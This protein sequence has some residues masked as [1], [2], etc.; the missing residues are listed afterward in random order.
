MDALSGERGGLVFVARTLPTRWRGASV[1][2][3]ADVRL[4]NRYGMEEPMEAGSGTG[5]SDF[6]RLSDL[7]VHFRP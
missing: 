3:V 1:S 6:V 7:D 4:A 2:L 5:R